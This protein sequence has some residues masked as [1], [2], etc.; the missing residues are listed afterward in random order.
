MRF[1][2]APEFSEAIQAAAGYF[3]LR[4]IFIEKDY[5]V[6]FVLKSLS[7]SEYTSDVIFKG[8]T[9]LSKAYNCIDR[10]SEDID[11]AILKTENHSGNQLTNKIKAVEK[12][13]SQGLEYFQHPNEEKKGRN[14]RTFYR[15]PKTLKDTDFS[16]VK[17]HI[18]IEINTFT[19]PVPH[20]DMPISSYL[21][22]FFR[23]GGFNEFIE[24][25][26]LKGFRIKVLARES[27]FFEKLFSL[28]RLSYEGPEKIKGK[29]R[30]FYDL[31]KLLGSTDLEEKIL[32]DANFE[33]INLVKQDD[34][35]NA[36]FTGDWITSPLSSSPLLL[37][38]DLTWKA[39]ERT[40]HTELPQLIWSGNPPSSE[41]ILLSLKQIK[42]FLQRYDKIR[43]CTSD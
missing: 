18:Q 19:N 37:D 5:W 34:A 28:I 21:T 42:E 26:D 41:E 24:E 31:C 2:Q 39:V 4:P 20:Q 29:I 1:H 23:Q 10:F 11:F 13:V 22:Q 40:Y 43:F 17:D 7:A 32:I 6:T 25:Y 14:R 38:I 3:K 36:I 30:H 33:L 12:T 27:T 8:G 15:Y 9:S 35:A 16:H